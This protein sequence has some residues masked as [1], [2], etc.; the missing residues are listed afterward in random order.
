L[1]GLPLIELGV[2]SAAAVIVAVALGTP[3]LLVTLVGL[4]AALATA[5]ASRDAADN[6]L[7]AVA[8]PLLLCWMVA[9]SLRGEPRALP[10]A[11]GVFLALGASAMIV[12]ERTGRG[13]FLQLA[14]QAFLIL[15]VLLAGQPLAGLVLGLVAFAQLLWEPALIVAHTRARYYQSLQVLWMAVILVAAHAVGAAP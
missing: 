5:L 11:T 2:S 13:L 6:E 9:L 7:V 15:S 3:T 8:L 1:L 4:A 14:P 12:V 10:M